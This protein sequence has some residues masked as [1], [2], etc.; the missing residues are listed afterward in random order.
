MWIDVLV[1]VWG[2]QMNGWT[3]TTLRQLLPGEQ[4]VMWETMDLEE[5]GSLGNLLARAPLVQAALELW[6]TR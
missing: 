5:L 6:N 2:Q 1:D 4:V 3:N